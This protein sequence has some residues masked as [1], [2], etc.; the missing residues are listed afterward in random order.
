MVCPDRLGRGITPLTRDRK[1]LPLTTVELQQ[2][3]SR[4]L[5]MT[6]KRVLDVGRDAEIGV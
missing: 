1:P 3:G 6:P 2:S 4:L 5:H